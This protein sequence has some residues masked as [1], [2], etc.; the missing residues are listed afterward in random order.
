MKPVFSARDPLEAH[1]LR[2]VLESEGLEAEVRGEY[3]PFDL[4]GALSVWVSDDSVDRARTVLD[5]FL[6]R[7][8][9]QIEP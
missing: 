8:D 4:N 3:V 1:L 6:R 5:Q 2:A 7:R 9:L